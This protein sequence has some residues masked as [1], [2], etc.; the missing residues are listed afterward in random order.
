MDVVHVLLE[1]RYADEELL[2]DLGVGVALNHQANDL[3]L[4]LGQVVPR[5]ISLRKAIVS[6]R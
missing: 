5:G 3:L 2:R 6:A 1:C 4:P